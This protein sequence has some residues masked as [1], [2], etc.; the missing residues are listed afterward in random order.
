MEKEIIEFLDKE[1]KQSFAFAFEYLDRR[2]DKVITKEIMYNT[3]ERA[4]TLTRWDVYCEIMKSRKVTRAAAI[5]GYKLAIENG[6]SDF[7]AVLLYNQQGFTINEM[8]RSKKERKVWQSLPD[9]ITLY[10]GCSKNELNFE[11]ENCFGISWTFNRQIA[12]IFAFGGNKQNRAVFSIEVCK[13]DIKAILLERNEDEVLFFD[14]N[15]FTYDVERFQMVTDRPTEYYNDYIKTEDNKR[16]I[17]EKS[18]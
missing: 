5:E 7:R 2:K 14:G 4:S 15:G 8:L 3:L 17:Y 13:E 16:K 6:E 18:A 11:E 9:K 12:E 10:R 1:Y